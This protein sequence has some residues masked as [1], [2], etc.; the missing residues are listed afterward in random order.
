MKSL[1]MYVD[2]VR[3]NVS[4]R[5]DVVLPT[6]TTRLATES[7]SGPNE[8]SEGPI[9]HSSKIWKITSQCQGQI[10]DIQRKIQRMVGD[11]HEWLH[12]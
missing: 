11:T 1:V 7:Q 10:T 12:C 5:S 3:F 2:Q 8:F 4:G 9:D 6:N